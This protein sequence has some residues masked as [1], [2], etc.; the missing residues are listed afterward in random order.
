MA[1]RLGASLGSGPCCLCPSS[2]AAPFC[3]LEGAELLFRRFVS[4]RARDATAGFFESK[5][6]L[7]IQYIR[8]GRA[9]VST[10]SAVGRFSSLPP[11]PPS[12]FSVFLLPRMQ[13]LQYRT[14]A[15]EVSIGGFQ[16]TD[17]NRE[18]AIDSSAADHGM[19]DDCW[20][21]IATSKANKQGKLQRARRR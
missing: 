1:P 4:L 14:T 6:P 20:E 3:L 10:I 12:L 11:P 21:T 17:C 15:R 13:Y 2:P 5:F 19:G 16:T 18:E 7:G 9:T 8:G